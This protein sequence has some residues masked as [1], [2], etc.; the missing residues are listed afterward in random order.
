MT[1]V[2]S[3]EKKAHGVHVCLC[4]SLRVR[5]YEKGLGPRIMP[6]S[7]GGVHA[8]LLERRGNGLPGEEAT[9]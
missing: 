4:A 1:S 7:K 9:A 3:A 6:P 8:H 5:V 2:W